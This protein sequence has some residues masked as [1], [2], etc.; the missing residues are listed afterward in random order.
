[1]HIGH[2]NEWIEGKKYCTKSET[3]LAYS[4]NGK[5]N[6]LECV[7]FKDETKFKVLRLWCAFE[8]NIALDFASLF[9][10][11]RLSVF[12]CSDWMVNN[13][14]GGERERKRGIGMLNTLKFKHFLHRCRNIPSQY[15]ILLLF[16]LLVPRFGII[17]Q[18][19][20]NL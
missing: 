20:Q 13:A 19:A 1:M 12:I 18:I 14:K 5:R 11:Y 10:F 7:N 16:L 15:N 17:E 9:N 6:G 8:S 2:I 4:S 3:N